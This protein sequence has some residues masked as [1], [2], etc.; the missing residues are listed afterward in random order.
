[1]NHQ[2]TNVSS[3]PAGGVG[4]GW[5]LKVAETDQP[6]LHLS[7]RDHPLDKLIIY[8][9]RKDSAFPQLQAAHISVHVGRLRGSSI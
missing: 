3:N 7:I 4:I 1:M 6:I 2:P 8:L 9:P 5:R